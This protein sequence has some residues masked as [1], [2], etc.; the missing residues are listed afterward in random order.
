MAIALTPAYGVTNAVLSTH[1]CCLSRI[2]GYFRGA[3]DS[4]LQIHDA[5]A[6]PAN[7]VVPLKSYQ[8]PNAAPFSWAFDPAEL[9]LAN[10]LVVAISTTEGTLTISAE[11]A[12]FLA[13]VWQLPQVSGTSVAGD[14]TTAVSSLSVWSNATGSAAVK[15]LFRI[16]ASDATLSTTRYLMLFTAT[17]SGDGGTPVQSWPITDAGSIDLDFGPIGLTPMNQAASGT[18]TKAC[19]F[20]L[21]DS[22]G[23]LVRS[24]AGSGETIYLKVTYK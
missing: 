15:R 7:G 20:Y 10:G 19:V 11:L 14:Y 21:S 3:V 5:K 8:L 18:Q 23:T 24:S 9:P 6:L 1:E 12:D 2:Q 13:D 4:W 22:N 16:E 17:Q